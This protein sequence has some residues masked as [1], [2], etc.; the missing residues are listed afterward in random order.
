MLY[1]LQIMRKLILGKNFV[2]KKFPKQK[3]YKLFNRTF[4]FKSLS[5]R[6]FHSSSFSFDGNYFFSYP[7][8]FFCK[9]I[10]L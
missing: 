6:I 10:F 1:T 9:N 8:N 4:P 7:V 5:I 3:N 2:T